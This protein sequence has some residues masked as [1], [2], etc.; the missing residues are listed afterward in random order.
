MLI[1]LYFTFRFTLEFQGTPGNSNTGHFLK[2]K[3]GAFS[4]SDFCLE[5]TKLFG[6]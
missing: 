4:S 1:Y 6:D 2:C 3:L 5:F